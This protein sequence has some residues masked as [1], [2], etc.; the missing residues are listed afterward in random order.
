MRPGEIRVL[1]LIDDNGD[2]KGLVCRD[3]GAADG[4]EALDGVLGGRSAS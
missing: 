2:L 4:K 3:R 1:V